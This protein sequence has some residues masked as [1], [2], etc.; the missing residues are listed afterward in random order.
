MLKVLF[1][2]SGSDFS[3]FRVA[4]KSIRFFFNRIYSFPCSSYLAIYCLLFYPSSL[5]FKDF[6]TLW[7][8]EALPY[9]INLLS[10]YG[11]F[12]FG[13]SKSCLFLFSLLLLIFSLKSRLLSCLICLNFCICICFFFYQRL[14]QCRPN[15]SFQHTSECLIIFNFN[16]NLRTI[17]SRLHAVV[18]SLTERISRIL[19]IQCLRVL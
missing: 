11:I 8:R 19:E 4:S 7:F 13:Q 6:I 2:L 1:Q 3:G 10:S 16:K 15:N 12:C 17:I 5:I 9:F 14:H 18:D